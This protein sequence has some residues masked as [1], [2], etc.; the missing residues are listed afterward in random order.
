MTTIWGFTQGVL[1]LRSFEHQGQHKRQ[2]RLRKHRLWVYNRM[3]NLILVS[4]G[5]GY[6]SPKDHSLVKFAVF[7]PTEATVSTCT[8]GRLF[9]TKYHLDWRKHVDT[10]LLVYSSFCNFKSI[11]NTTNFE[12]FLLFQVIFTFYLT[13]FCKV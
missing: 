13:I 1:E 11:L 2:N 8:N 7:C 6:R 5:N 12:Q 4:Q 3:P 9:Y 10:V